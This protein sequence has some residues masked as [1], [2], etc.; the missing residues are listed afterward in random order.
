MSERTGGWIQTFSKVRFYPLD[1]RPEDIRLEDIAH[2]LALQCRF[3]GHCREFYSVAQHSVVVSRMCGNGP[4]GYWGLFHD[5]SEAYL[6]DIARPVKH[7]PSMAWYR[8]AEARLQALIYDRFGLEGN[9]PESVKK[10]DV[11]ALGWEAK[12]YMAPLV[13]EPA[14][15]WCMFMAHM[16]VPIACAWGPREAEERF[17]ERY[18]ELRRI[19]AC[20]PGAG[21]RRALRPDILRLPLNE[22]IPNK[23][24]FVR[25]YN[26]LAN[27]GIRTVGEL[28]HKK[29]DELLRIKN[30]G[31]ST[32]FTVVKLL[33][34]KGLSLSE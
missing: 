25:M 2:A 8:S 22:F 10:A 30:M 24:G 4:D 17:L 28:I 23:P 32:L 31:A 7:D 27:S 11:Y 16:K 5:A 34:D 29:P 6:S 18:A 20:S 26:C 15:E 12:T 21:E 33:E 9:E 1:P 13:D 14:W 3:T 19:A